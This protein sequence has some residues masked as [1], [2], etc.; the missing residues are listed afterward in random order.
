M[1]RIQQ[2][3]LSNLQVQEQYFNPSKAVDTDKTKETE[4]LSFGEILSQ[5]AR[6]TADS[7]P[8]KFSKHASNRL[9]DRK[10]ELT[11]SQMDRLAEGTQRAGMKGI[12]DSLVMIDNLAFIVNV[13]NHTVVTALDQTQAE[14]KIF[15]NIDGAVIA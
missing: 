13:P 7:E 14:E 9:A 4:Q 11:S 10:I 12:R 6:E 15:T 1:N 5:K 3:F 8:I 2:N